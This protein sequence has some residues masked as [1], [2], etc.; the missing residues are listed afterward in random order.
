MRGS[1]KQNVMIILM[2]DFPSEACDSQ[3]STERKPVDR[4]IL[5]F[6]HIITATR[7]PNLPKWRESFG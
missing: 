4:S 1:A 3:A 5:N 6:A 2:D 7:L